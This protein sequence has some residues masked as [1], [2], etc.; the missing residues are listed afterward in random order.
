MSSEYQWVSP[1]AILAA[2]EV[3]P[4]GYFL[5]EFPNN[6][7]QENDILH[8]SFRRDRTDDFTVT[9]GDP[10]CR[11]ADTGETCD[12][13]RALIRYCGAVGYDLNYSVVSLCRFAGIDP[14]A[15]AAAEEPEDP[16]GTGLPAPAPE[17]H[18]RLAEY[19]VRQKRIP[20]WLV[21]QLAGWG[22]LY[23]AA[24]G[25]IVFTDPART[26]AEILDPDTEEREFLSAEP[27]GFWWFKANDP[28]SD[29]AGAYIC[30]TAVDALSLRLIHNEMEL[31]DMYSYNANDL[32]CVTGSTVD[33]TAVERIWRGMAEAGRGTVLALGRSDESLRCIAQ[34]E[35]MPRTSPEG[36]SWSENW[37]RLM[38][39]SDERQAAKAQ[40]ELRAGPQ[41]GDSGLPPLEGPCDA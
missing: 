9:K 5:S 12:P 30:E 7:R 39:E 25:R 6:V 35:N 16:P 10:V 17:P 20:D 1:D 33:H 27:G 32:Y 11:I 34:Y 21:R 18:A 14:T 31:G 3:D 19:L 24:D 41:S 38:R 13:L 36:M 22:Q 29:A 40:A 8:V 26:C 37:V 28:E 15:S 4:Y 23:Q 2:Q